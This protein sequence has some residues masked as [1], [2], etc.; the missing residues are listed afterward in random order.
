MRWAW[1][2]PFTHNWGPLV[3]SPRGSALAGAHWRGYIPSNASVRDV[4]RSSYTVAPLYPVAVVAIVR[5]RET[6]RLRLD[7]LSGGWKGDIARFQLTRCI[8]TQ[9]GKRVCVGRTERTAY[10]APPTVHSMRRASREP[11][12]GG[13]ARCQQFV[14]SGI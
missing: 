1:P 2:Q 13:T 8:R 4:D 11:S 12:I 6:A 5:Q 9:A 14:S 10:A 3:R 7:A